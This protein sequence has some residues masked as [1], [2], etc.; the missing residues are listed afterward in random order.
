MASLTFPT[1]AGCIAGS[2]T[3]ALPPDGAPG[4]HDRTASLKVMGGAADPEVALT[5]TAAIS[6]GAERGDLSAAA[7]ID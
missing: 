4:A 2:I 1:V 3:R 5:P 6:S 7:A